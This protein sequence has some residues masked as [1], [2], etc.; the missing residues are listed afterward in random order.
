MN[1]IDNFSDI[2]EATSENPDLFQSD[3][4]TLNVNVWFN[5]L[6][7]RLQ[8]CLIKENVKDGFMQYKMLVEYAEGL[9]LSSGKLD[10][11]EYLKEVEELKEKELKESDPNSVKEMRESMIKWKIILKNILKVKKSDMNLSY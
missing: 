11:K 4:E 9:A 5:K 6:E 10:K 3:L 1:E 7:N 2:D 8:Y